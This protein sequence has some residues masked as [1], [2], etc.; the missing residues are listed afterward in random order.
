MTNLF[1]KILP[2]A[3]IGIIGGG[4]LGKMLSVAA[5]SLGYK[6]IVL[7]P[8]ENCCSKGV[9]DELIIS[10]YDDKSNLKKLAQKTDVIT[11]EFENIPALSVEWIE[12]CGGYIP[13]S[14]NALAI[15]QDRYLEKTKLQEAGFE[16]APFLKI[17]NIDQLKEGCEKLKLPCI[18]KTRTGGYDG[19]GQLTI[20]NIE[21]VDTAKLLLQQPCILE[22]KINFEKELSVIAVK[23][24][25]GEIDIFPIGTNI[26]KNGILHTTFVLSNIENNLEKKLEQS[27]KNFFDLH[28][29]KGILTIELFLAD[30]KII[31]NEIAPRPH[32]S[33][34]W[35]IDGANVSQFEQHIR[36]ICSLPLIK[37]EI[38]QPTSMVNLLGQHYENLAK[39][40]EKIGNFSKIHIYGKDKNVENRKIGHITVVDKNI[41]TL[42]EKTKVIEEVIKE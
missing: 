30:K 29:I 10:E 15:S 37:S 12:K 13:Q 16:V 8:N 25:N 6:T 7:D 32:N 33:G 24:V 40:I 35:T 4:Q 1:K 21:E 26:H 38:L 42:I 36:A 41:E 28:N 27:I 39:N 2:P 11:F 18:L 17:D 22:K 5:K 20:N 19:K 34:H 31:A 9:C 14:Y 3:T 23:S